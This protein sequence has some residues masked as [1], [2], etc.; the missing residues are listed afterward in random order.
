[1]PGTQSPE[2]IIKLAI[3]V[4]AEGA[5]FYRSLAR[6]ARDPAARDTFLSLADDEDRHQKDLAGILAGRL[7]EDRE[8]IFPVDFV[9]ILN[10]GLASLKESFKG[11]QPVDADSLSIGS[12]VNIGIRNERAAIET[13]EKMLDIFPEDLCAVLERITMEEKVHLDK[14]L[15]IKGTL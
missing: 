2:V 11:A 12:A 9:Q 5:A 13:Y 7:P 3:Q 4:E 10:N 1:M 6:L 8:F 15:K 14:L